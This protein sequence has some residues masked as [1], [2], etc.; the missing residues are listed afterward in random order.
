MAVSNSASLLDRELGAVID[1]FDHVVRFNAAP[2]DREYAPHVGTKTTI[3]ACSDWPPDL[4]ARNRSRFVDCRRLF[5]VPD[6]PGKEHVRS[7]PDAEEIP[8][9]F[10]RQLREQ[11]QPRVGAWCTT[12]LIT[13]AWLLREFEV[14]HTVGWY[15]PDAVGNEQVFLQHYDSQLSTRLECHH[16]VRAE[17]RLFNQWAAAGRIAALEGM[18]ESARRGV[19]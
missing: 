1:S 10:E 18:P 15:G 17:A 19:R 9:S 6:L 12:G 11:I 13:L 5:V 4:Y 2:L 8:R 14:I 3:W 7:P 16:A